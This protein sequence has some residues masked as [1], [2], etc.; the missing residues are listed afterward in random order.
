MVDDQKLTEMQ[1]QSFYDFLRKEVNLSLKRYN[2][3]SG[4]VGEGYVND[5]PAAKMNRVR[6]MAYKNKYISSQ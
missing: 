2:F 1:A 5:S 3:S 6:E 4:K